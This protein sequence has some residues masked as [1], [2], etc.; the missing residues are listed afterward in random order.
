MYPRPLQVVD[1]K[2]QQ[3]FAKFGVDFALRSRLVARQCGE[4]GLGSIVFFSDF[5]AGWSG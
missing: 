4:M 5:S 2:A 3:R 1:A